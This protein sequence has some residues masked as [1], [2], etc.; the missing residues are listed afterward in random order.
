MKRRKMGRERRK[1][2]KLSDSEGKNFKE[3]K[4]VSELKQN[5]SLEKENEKKE[6]WEYEN[7]NTCNRKRE[8]E[9]ERERER[10]RE[11]GGSEGI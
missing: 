8:R 7:E 2:V 4:R 10:K 9:R 3:L 5:E 6:E 11:R 1:W